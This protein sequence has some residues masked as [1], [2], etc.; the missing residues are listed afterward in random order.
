MWELCKP[1]F[2]HSLLLLQSNKPTPIF[3]S[4]S[5]QTFRNWVGGEFGRQSHCYL[6]L[7]QTEMLLS[8]RGSMLDSCHYYLEVFFGPFQNLP[9]IPQTFQ[10]MIFYLNIQ[11]GVGT[12]RKTVP[13]HFQILIK[14][15]LW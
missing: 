5:Q 11:M 12:K 2:S 7:L 9:C 13:T 14:I 15:Y 10:F 4:E 1:R 6:P 8:W 3:T